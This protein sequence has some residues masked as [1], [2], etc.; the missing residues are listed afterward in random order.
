MTKKKPTIK[1]LTDIVNK[2]GVALAQ[3]HGGIRQLSAVL[4]MYMELDIN[5][6]YHEVTN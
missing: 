3:Q 6:W 2:Q 1:E 4:R 5:F